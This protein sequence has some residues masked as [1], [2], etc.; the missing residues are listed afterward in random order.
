MESVQSSGWISR[1]D[2]SISG[3]HLKVMSCDAAQSRTGRKSY[4]WAKSAKCFDYFMRLDTSIFISYYY[5]TK[6]KTFSFTSRIQNNTKHSGPIQDF[7]DVVS[8]S[9]KRHHRIRASN[10]HSFYRPAGGS[11]GSKDFWSHSSYFTLIKSHRTP[12]DKNVTKS[13]FFSQYTFFAT[14]TKKFPGLN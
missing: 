10:L 8:R 6:G 7:I 14:T 12:P 4:F 3:L 11:S 1:T 13:I 9:E 5:V 2:D